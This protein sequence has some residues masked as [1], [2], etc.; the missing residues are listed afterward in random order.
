MTLP[1]YPMTPTEFED[2]FNHPSIQPSTGVPTHL[3]MSAGS[4]FD[5][6]DNLGFSSDIGGMVF[7]KQD[8]GVYECH[9]YFL[10]GSGGK[11]ILSTAKA[12]ISEMFTHHEAYVIVGY[13]PR[14]NRAVRVIGTALGFHKLKNADCLDELGRHCET[15]VLRRCT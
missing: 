11:A 5:T 1:I 8:E 4:L 2:L 14:G 10:P 12:M 13:P 9:F 6:P 15:Y 7:R 3:E